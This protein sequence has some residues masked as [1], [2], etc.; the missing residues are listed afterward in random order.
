MGYSGLGRESNDEKKTKLDFLY[1]EEALYLVEHVK[2][3]Q[4]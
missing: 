4:N 2:I 3:M 1:P